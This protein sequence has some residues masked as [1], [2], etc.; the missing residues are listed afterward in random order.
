[1]VWVVTGSLVR[2]KEGGLGGGLPLTSGAAP[3][4]D[5]MRAVYRQ[6]AVL[7]DHDEAAKVPLRKVVSLIDVATSLDLSIDWIGG[8]L[9]IR[10]S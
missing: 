6:S 10:R 2:F 7:T 9:Q 1:M 3:L 8:G 4:E 5:R